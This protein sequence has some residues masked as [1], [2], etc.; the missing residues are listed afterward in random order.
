V[1]GGIAPELWTPRQRSV[2]LGLL[3]IFSL[4]LIILLTRNPAYVS[5]PQPPVPARAGEVEDRIDPNTADAETLAAL[6]SIGPQRA[7][8]I[9]NYRE[10]FVAA[11]PGALAF[12]TREDLMNIRGI[13][14]GIMS[15][16]APFMKFPPA[17]QPA[18]S[19]PIQ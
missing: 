9:V 17:S 10:Q 14:V 4:F 3:C 19:S 18:T 7:Q 13:G 15:Q 12:T 8:D 1:S 5:N 2:L 6:P 11:H 16:I